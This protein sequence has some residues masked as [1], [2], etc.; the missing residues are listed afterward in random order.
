LL[1]ISICVPAQV[2]TSSIN[3]TVV[4]ANGAPI[5]LATIKIT[6]VKTGF[7]RITQSTE[8]GNFSFTALPAG[9]YSMSADANGFEPV[10]NVSVVLEPNTTRGVNFRLSPAQVVGV[11]TI[12]SDP[13]SAT[14]SDSVDEK[15]IKSLPLIHGDAYLLG[16]LYQRLFDSSVLKPE[17]NVAINGSSNRTNTYM[18]DGGD[19]TDARSGGALP[20]LPR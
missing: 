3:G 11:V 9:T 20:S 4:D 19:T 7:E 6:S 17:N 13:S 18:V 10:R 1:S 15:V 8:Q 16:G 5:P 14:V 12:T 2:G